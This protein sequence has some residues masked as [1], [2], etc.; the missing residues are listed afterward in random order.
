MKAIVVMYDSLNRRMLPPYGCDWIKAPN[1]ER[2]AKRSAMF[3]NCYVG[4]MACIPAR[5][6]LHTGRHNFLHRSWGPLE[7]FD[8]SMPDML[9]RNGIYTHLASDHRHYWEDGGSTYHTRYDSWEFFR[10]QEGDPWKGEV[11]DP[12]RPFP[13]KGASKQKAARQD[14]VNRQYFPTEDLHPQTLTFDAGEHFIRKNHDAGSWFLQIETFDPHEPFVSYPRY[15]EL[16]AHE[17]RGPHFDWPSY[18]PLCEDDT[19]DEILHVRAEYASLVSMCDH[20][21][22]RVLDLMDEL[23]LWKDTMLIVCT[24][25]GFMLG[26]HGWWA[27]TAQPWFNELANTPL[28]IWDPRSAR[29]GVRRNALVQTIDLAPTILDFFGIAP[30]PDMQG[31]PLRDAVRCDAPVRTAAL[32]GMH[33]EHV[34]VTD[35]RYVYMRSGP[36]P[37]NPA[38]IYEY[39]L[40]PMHMKEMFGVD[41]LADIQLA[42]PFSFTKGVRTMKIAARPLGYSYRAGTL[43]FDLASD[44][45]QANP[46]VDADVERRM[47][48]LLRDLM[49]QSDAPAEQYERIGLP[50]E[51]SIA[52]EH[53]LA[54]AHA[55]RAEALRR[56]FARQAMAMRLAATGA[57]TP[58]RQHDQS[59]A[60]G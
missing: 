10:G 38:P 16:Y 51:G 7:P 24:D 59:T 33:G 58:S 9:S 15:R 46:I 42:E 57:T 14:W 1:F 5:R 41:E 21:L 56:A 45:A 12:P 55:G 48:G 36:D 11:R 4:S 44:P 3:D 32:F 50:S 40:M 52:D 27:K 30:T 25:H 17:Y 29:A 60:G 28:F 22:G 23:D 39:T 19:D 20:S 34:N 43:L 13:M 26:E 2:L 47:A 6:E 31:V 35:G 8:D 37:D 53:L 54:A 49:V 18:G